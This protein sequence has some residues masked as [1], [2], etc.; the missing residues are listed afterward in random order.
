MS[1][2]HSEPTAMASAMVLAKG[3][4]HCRT[5]EDA[6]RIALYNVNRGHLFARNLELVM[7]FVPALKT[8]SRIH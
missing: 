5:D 4:D 7:I 1:E 3:V 2:P 8:M 6:R